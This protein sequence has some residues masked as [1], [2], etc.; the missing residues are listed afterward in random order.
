MKAGR[1]L[2]LSLLFLLPFATFGG[3]DEAPWYRQGANGD[4][5]LNLYFFWSEHC[6]H[7][8]EARPFISTLADELPWLQVQSR[9]LDGSG[10]KLREFQQM[11]QKFGREASS[12]PAFFFCNTMLVGYDDE[13]NIGRYI[14]ERLQACR[15]RL[16]AGEGLPPQ[17]TPEQ[18][19]ATLFT[20]F[21]T[22]NMSLPL[23]TLSIAALDA[24]NP[25]A[26]FVLLFLLSLLTRAGSRRR[27]LLIGGVFVLFSGLIYFLFM[28]AW[29]NLFLLMGAL[30][31]VTAAAGAFAVIFAMIN[32]KDYFLMGTGPSLSLSQQAKP[33]IFQRMRGLLD[34]DN[35]VTLLTGTVLLAVVVNSYELLCTSGLPMVYT[36]LLTLES[37]S[38]AGYY[39]YLGLYNLVYVLPLLLIVLLF[40]R[41]LGARKLQ[42]REGR[43]LK[44]LS[45]LMMLGL[46]GLLLIAPERLVDIGLAFSLILG[47][48]LLTLL[49]YGVER[50]RSGG[51]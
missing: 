16:L 10:E 38:T 27:I 35:L 13:E 20:G 24:F 42:L 32:I 30:G 17:L 26:F 5:E 18:A 45:G 28:A 19:M 37:L 21:D 1:Y 15:Q 9:Q 14:R 33:G 50:Y 11:A 49:A 6:P 22:S 4:V 40:A 8:L 46:G 31:W 48:L 43:L 29:L 34:A 36:R 23:L 3:E 7:C 12:Y 44:L 51:E 41:S 47:A 25:C 2:L 39:L